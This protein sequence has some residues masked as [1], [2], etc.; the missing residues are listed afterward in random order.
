MFCRPALT[1]VHLQGNPRGR[2]AI[3]DDSGPKRREWVIDEILLA[4]SRK[5]VVRDP[6]EGLGRGHVERQVDRRRPRC[7][8]CVG[9]RIEDQ[10]IDKGLD[11][12]GEAEAG[13]VEPE[14]HG[15]T[16]R[17]AETLD[18]GT[19]D[20]AQPMVGSDRKSVV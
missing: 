8:S 2:R 1:Q 3:H 5:P 11:V 9:E 4:Q 6:Q 20:G 16:G 19:H 17:R 13:L 10:P 12:G 15:Q 14:H 7:V 18:P